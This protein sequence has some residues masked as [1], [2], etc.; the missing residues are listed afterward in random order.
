MVRKKTTQ[1][2]EDQGIGF[3]PQV[4]FSTAGNLAGLV[5]L[6]A[7][8]IRNALNHGNAANV[9][10][11]VVE[12]KVLRILDDGNGISGKSSGMDARGRPRRSPRAAFGCWIGKS[13]AEGTGTGARLS[14]LAMC[15]FLEVVTCPKDEPGKTY[16]CVIHLP[17][18]IEQLCD[19]TWENP[20]KDVRREATPF[21]A[22]LAH[23]T[24]VILRDFRASDRHDPFDEK[25]MRNTSAQ[26]TTE[27]VRRVIPM[28]LP[29]F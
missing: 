27:E 25:R 17:T 20:W 6:L 28:A 13:Q 18:F 10:V 12:R 14:A 22:E 9:Y 8:I 15:Q 26:I 24:L 21:P 3:D 19:G 5:H 11:E 1:D 4:W 2:G 23:G 16:H 7:E 29:P